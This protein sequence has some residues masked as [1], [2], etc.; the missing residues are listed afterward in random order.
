[1]YTPKQVFVF[2]P[3]L[4]SVS[5]LPMWRHFFCFPL[6]PYKYV[7]FRGIFCL[8]LMPRYTHDRTLPVRVGQ[9]PTPAPMTPE[10]HLL[11]FLRRCLCLQLF[12]LPFHTSPV[13]DS[14]V[15]LCASCSDW[16]YFSS[17]V[18]L[19]FSSNINYCCVQKIIAGNVISFVGSWMF[20]SLEQWLGIETLPQISCLLGE[21]SCL[22]SD[23]PACCTFLYSFSCPF[24]YKLF[25]VRTAFG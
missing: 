23:C 21:I 10:I 14:I 15:F 5:C 22:A 11:L 7:A 9:L 1:M 6:W 12:G 13:K 16:P 3:D 24:G 20:L 17:V 25:E 4:S 19:F 2:S 8:I 18:F